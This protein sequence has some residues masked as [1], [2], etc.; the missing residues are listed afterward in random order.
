MLTQT[1][2]D[3]TRLSGPDK[4]YGYRNG[5]LLVTAGAVDLALNKTA[6]QSSTFVNGGVTFSASR[7]G[8]VLVWKKL[9]SV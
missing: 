6:T 1:L 2:T 8:F 9:R 7:D 3:N 5:Q 4:E